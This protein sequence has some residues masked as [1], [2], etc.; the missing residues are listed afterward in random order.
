MRL[1]QPVFSL[2]ITILRNYCFIP[3]SSQDLTGHSQY[4]YGRLVLTLTYCEQDRFSTD[5]SFSARVPGISNP[6]SKKNSS[7]FIFSSTI[8]LKEKV[9]ALKSEIQ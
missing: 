8:V 7:D 9:N 4:D 5:L 3:I 6:C 1:C 2:H